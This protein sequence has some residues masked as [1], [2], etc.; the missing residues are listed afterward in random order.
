MSLE[1]SLQKSLDATQRTFNTIRTGRAN[2]SLLDKVMVDYYGSETPLKSLASL[3]TPDAQTIQ[4]QPFDRGA[5]GDIEKAIAMS[6]LGLT[7]N[8]DGQVIR[9]NIPPLT[10]D[11]RKTLSKLAAKYAEEGK[12]ALRNIRRDAIDKVKKREKDGELSEDQSHDAQARIQKTLDSF[13][14]TL[15]ARLKEKEA[16]ILKV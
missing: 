15:E 3:S 8:N 2:T 6:G 4:I 12:V 5:M 14:R 16:E 7:P 10:E 9:I 13:I 11:R 1:A